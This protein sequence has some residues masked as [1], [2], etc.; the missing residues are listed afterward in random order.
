M[1][2]LSGDT[3]GGSAGGCGLGFPGAAF[4]EGSRLQVSILERRE[5]E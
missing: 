1:P 4:L 5:A 3:G 2:H